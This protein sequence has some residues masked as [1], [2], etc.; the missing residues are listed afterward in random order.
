MHSSLM[1]I[2]SNRNVQQPHSVIF[3]FDPAPPK[4]ELISRFE[5]MNEMM[6]WQITLEL[7]IQNAE[8][9]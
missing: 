3:G 2:G 7:Q 8:Y 5:I 6:H 9:S 1:L 4:F